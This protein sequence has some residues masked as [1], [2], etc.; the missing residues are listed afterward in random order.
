MTLEPEGAADLKLNRS[1]SENCNI[2][3]DKQFVIK[4]S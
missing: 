2:I 4:V 1:K 3:T